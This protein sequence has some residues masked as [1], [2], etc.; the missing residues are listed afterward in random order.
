MDAVAGDVVDLLQAA[1]APIRPEHAG[2]K[3]RSELGLKQ[4]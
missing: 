2:R 3:A 1:K 4:V